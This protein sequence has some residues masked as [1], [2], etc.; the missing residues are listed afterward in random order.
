MLVNIRGL[1][2][3]EW[4]TRSSP[5]REGYE[6]NWALSG[7]T[8]GSMI[9][10]GQHTG[11][12]AQIAS[13]DVGNVVVYI[14]FNDYASTHA[15]FVP[16]CRGTMSDNDIDTKN[17][18]VIADITTA[19]TDLLAAGTTRIVLA[20]IRDTTP[21]SSAAAACDEGGDDLT[22]ISDAIDVVNAGL[23][24][25]ATAESIALVVV[26]DENATVF[27]LFEECADESPYCL[28]VGGELIDIGKQGD[29]PHFGSLDDV[30]WHK[31]TVFSGWVYANRY[32]IDYFNDYYSLS[33]PLLTDQEIL[34]E[35][36]I[37]PAPTATASPTAPP[38]TPTA[39]ATP[40]NTPPTPTASPTP[41]NP[42]PT[43][44]EKVTVCHKGKTSTGVPANAVPAHLAHG[45]TLGPCS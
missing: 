20:T 22:R 24:S 37:T 26:D 28:D 3:G 17:A 32:F 5:R 29:E 27:G 15:D 19:V 9:S 41:T 34:A 16:M 39:T 40:T 13:G 38:P 12:A 21:D 43:P 10:T 11:L 33:I 31:G 18:A 8:A 14:G 30:W 23:A 2:F 36:G 45:D 6:Y 25:L 1:D 44:S 35:A 4:G 7:A 42:P